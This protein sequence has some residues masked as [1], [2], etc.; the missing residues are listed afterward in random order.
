MN[1]RVNGTGTVLVIADE[2]ALPANAEER[3]ERLQKVVKWIETHPARWYQPSWHCGTSHC[4]AG[5]AQLF[6]RGID[7][8]EDFGDYEMPRDAAEDHGLDPMADA[9]RWL[10]LTEPQ[11]RGLFF[12]TNTLD[13]VDLRYR[14]AQIIESPYDYEAMSDPAND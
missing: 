5:V 3:N 11:Y 6:A 8:D 4:V 7:L 13:F 2:V 14:V 9:S 10:G 12:Y 1:A